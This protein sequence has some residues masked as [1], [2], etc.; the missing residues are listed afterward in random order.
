M[1]QSILTATGDE[2]M[3]A[4]INTLCESLGKRLEKELN[5]D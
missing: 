5:Q 4:D 2:Q 1:A 3:S